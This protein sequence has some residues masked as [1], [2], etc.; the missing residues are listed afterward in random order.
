MAVDENT[1]HLQPKQREMVVILVKNMQR[2][3]HAE[4]ESIVP[5]IMKIQFFKEREIKHDNCIHVAETL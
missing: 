1:K 4:L 2:R 5:M 3:T